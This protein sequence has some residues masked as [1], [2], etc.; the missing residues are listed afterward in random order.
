MEAV[1]KGFFPDLSRFLTYYFP[2]SWDLISCGEEQCLTPFILLFSNKIRITHPFLAI[3]AL[4]GISI[5][6]FYG[7]QIYQTITKENKISKTLYSLSFFFFL[8]MNFGGIIF[9]CLFPPDVYLQGIINQGIEISIPKLTYFAHV[10][11]V[12]STC[13]A[14]LSFLFGR[15]QAIKILKFQSLTFYYL[16][17]FTIYIIGFIGIIPTSPEARF[18]SYIPFL[19]EILYPGVLSTVV[20]LLPFCNW[21]IKAYFNLFL[22]FI[23]CNLAFGSAML[24]RYI[25]IYLGSFY[26]AAGLCFFFSDIIFLILYSL[27]YIDDEKKNNLTQNKNKKSN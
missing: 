5:G 21:P 22:G 9:H 23:A 3:S 20:F 4:G 11:D 27:T 12:C 10:I 15:L 6:L 7:L 26:S 24:E 17:F 8:M 2:S 19:P 1:V 16:L 18:G 14:C 25:W 13:C